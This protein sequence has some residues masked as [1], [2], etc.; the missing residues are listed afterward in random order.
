MTDQPLSPDELAALRALDTP[1]VCNALELLLPEA[2]VNGFTYE[3]F[4]CAFPELPP[5]VGYARTA[6]VRAMRPSSAEP[7]EIRRRRLAYYEYVESG[8]PAPSIAVIQDLD[9][10]PGFGAFWGEVQTAIHKG[11]GCLG[12][13]TNGSI[14]DL[15][16][17][18]KG[19]QLLAGKVC[20]SHAH[21]HVADHGTDVNVH[22]MTVRSGDL[23]H[24][25]RH[26]A[27]VIPHEL[28]REVPAKAELMARREKVI[29]DVAK[30]SGFTFEKL[31]R[32]IGEADEIH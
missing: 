12:T 2:R 7:A 3:P 8:G 15:D 28:A 30:A 32:A 11:L 9:W 22:G 24:A 14:R 17:A 23:V 26:G 6:L 13:I 29:L 4:F 18:A 19:F 21:V 20:P 10:N 31:Q 5:I 25:D 1:T 16:A 27:V